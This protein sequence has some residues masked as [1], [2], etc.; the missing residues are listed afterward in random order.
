MSIPDSL[1][2]WLAS[3][4]RGISS[5]TMVTHLTGIDAM[6]QWSRRDH[7]H[8][9]DDLHRCRLLLEEV[10]YLQ[11]MLPRMATCSPAWAALVEHWQELC[12]LMDKEAPHWKDGHGSAPK[13]YARMRELIEGARKRPSSD[14]AVQDVA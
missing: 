4:Q 6:G 14:A 11:L 10:T 13:T 5:N 3:G 9:P 2:R 1:V 8:D 7:P 12:D